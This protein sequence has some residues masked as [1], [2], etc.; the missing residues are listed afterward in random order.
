MIAKYIKAIQIWYLWHNIKG[1]TPFWQPA[2]YTFKRSAKWQGFASYN[3]ESICLVFQWLWAEDVYILID[4]NTSFTFLPRFFSLTANLFPQLSLPQHPQQSLFLRP[5]NTKAGKIIYQRQKYSLSWDE[6]KL[7]LLLNTIVLCLY[8]LDTKLSNL[9]LNY[10][11]TFNLFAYQRRIC[12]IEA[13]I[14]ENST[15]K[16]HG[17]GGTKKTVISEFIYSPVHQILR[18]LR[19]TKPHL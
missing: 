15:I 6:F 3:L 10:W 19:S 13:C 16:S 14:W 4:N 5:K 7:Q 12:S 17:L 9:L 11:V 8:F 1:T 18:S 2:I